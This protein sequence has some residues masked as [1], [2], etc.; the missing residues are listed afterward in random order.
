MSY[1]LKYRPKPAH[2]ALVIMAGF[3]VHLA[4]QTP[5]AR[6]ANQTSP[7]A[8]RGGRG[9][10]GDYK[11]YDPA[12]IDQG[13]GTFSQN[14]AFCHGANAK[15]G[16]SGPDLLRSLTVLHDEDGESIGQVVLNGRPRQGDAE[17]RLFERS[18]RRR[19]C[20]SPR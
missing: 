19:H 13:K 16:E 2:V 5:A 11:D 20:L 10:G 6:P 15:G 3:T 17:V 8:R 14:C 18:N 1:L 4:A 7:P 9:A 12:L